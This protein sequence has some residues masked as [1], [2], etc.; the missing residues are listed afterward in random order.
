MTTWVVCIMKAW[1]ILPLH[2]SLELCLMCACWA[3]T[4]Q[5]VCIPLD[6]LVSHCHTGSM[7]AAAYTASQA[8][9][10][11]HLQSEACLPCGLLWNVALHLF[12]FPLCNCESTDTCVSSYCSEYFTE[13]HM[14]MRETERYLS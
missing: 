8:L 5:D 3:R 6:V 2:N 7:A 10:Q 12:P 1:T 4:L 11:M 13:Y 14:R 9:L